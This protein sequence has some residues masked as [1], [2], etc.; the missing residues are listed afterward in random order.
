MGYGLLMLGN[1][2]MA[3]M[4]EIARLAERTGCDTLWL[5]DERFYR[6]VYG[7]L[8]Y[9]AGQTS[10]VKLGPCVTDPYSRHPAL[11]A[12]AIA[13]L[14]EI[15]GGR[16]VLGIGAGISG[17]GELGIERV[18]PARAIRE[19]IELIRRLLA[20]ETVT[21]QGEVISFREGRLSFRPIRP[22]I[23][24]VV[25]TNGPLGKRMA[26]AVADAVIME[27]AANAEEIRALR[28]EISAGARAAGRDPAAVRLIARLNTCI[29]ADGA[30]ARDA[31]RP[32]VARLLGARRLKFATAER[33]GLTL[34][35]EAV[36][37]VRGAP[38]AAGVTPYL[39]LL[40]LVTDR[41]VDAFTLAGTPAE[42]AAHVAELRAAGAD[43]VIIMPF[44][45]P[46]GSIEATIE[47]FGTEVWPK[48]AAGGGPA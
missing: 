6:E 13:T 2:P 11:T 39:P 12:M 43:S 33:Q 27:A 46:G 8:A 24:V 10:R 41:H 29:A 16:A 37:S 1:Q 30:A 20:G 48:A 44:A 18:K 9:L 47:A 42:V 22:E 38:Y 36:A 45:A 7:G 5:A 40:P 28:A 26:G 19:A 3:R 25:A 14:D 23:P 4:G 34:P 31:L 21:Y 32:T 15:S 17:F 35:E